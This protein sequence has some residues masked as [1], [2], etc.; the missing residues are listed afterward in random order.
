MRWYHLIS[1][2]FGGAFFVNALPHF[3]M[4]VTG[5]PFQSP[6]GSPPG[7]G[8]SSA[9]SNVLWG[10]ANFIAAYLLLGKVGN[11][12][13]RNLLHILPAAVGALTMAVIL[14]RSFGRFYNGL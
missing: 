2:F 12:V 9:L 7:E 6:F 11:F 4:G 8:T 3:M 1:Y 5:H 13:F 10:T 14:A